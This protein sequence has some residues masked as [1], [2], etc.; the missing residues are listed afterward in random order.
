LNAT[1]GAQKSHMRLKALALKALV[2]AVLRGRFAKD[3][4]RF[5]LNEALAKALDIGIAW[6]CH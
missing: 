4:R 3:Q 6:L 2:R 1:P 5:V